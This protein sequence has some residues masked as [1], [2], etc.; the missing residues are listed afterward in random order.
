MEVIKKYKGQIY[1]H[2]MLNL[3]CAAFITF[4]SFSHYPL[5][6]FRAYLF[7]GAHFLAI[8]WS[9]FGF[10][11]F[12][13]ADKRF[14]TVFFPILFVLFSSI[15]F[16][17]YVQDI[18]IS[19]GI[20]Q[21][22]L[23]TKPDIVFGLI[24]WQF[25]LYF[26]LSVITSIILVWQRRKLLVNAWK[27]P[28]LI[29]ALIG[30][31][32]FF[33]TENYR[34]GSFSRR[35]P[36]NVFY[37]STEYFQQNDLVFRSVPASVKK[38]TDSLNVILVLGESV[39]AD[40]LQLN[41][42]IRQTTPLLSA[43]KN[44]IT[45]PDAFTPLTYTGASVPQIMTDATFSDSFDKPKYSLISVLKQAGIRTS[46]IG[47]QTPEK[48]FEMFP[49]QASFS[50]ILDPMHSE[51]SFR[52]DYDEKLLPVFDNVFSTKGNAFTAIHLMG[53][54]WWYETR[55]PSAFRIFQ[56]VINSKNVTSNSPEQLI[57]SYNNTILYM[58]YVVDKLIRK[59]EEKP[60]NTL[61]IY[62]SD[63]GEMLGEN[64]QWLHAQPG[65]GI[66]N[67]GLFFWYSDGF[68]KKYPQLI[69]RLESIRLKHTELE[70]FFPTVIDLFGI[71]GI[72]NKKSLLHLEKN[73]N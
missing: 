12:V 33:V 4:A 58:D 71:K 31:A 57:N 37:A 48:S 54:H 24:S 18:A 11:Y 34:T 46:W 21:V 41:G 69:K 27:S 63:H 60:S 35:L 3:A 28:L 5:H 8:Q 49:K 64:N 39:R 23:E 16:W 38:T 73:I 9:V 32:I 26:V 61:V 2:L 20:V 1:F 43:R 25:L 36:Y 70:F 66:S 44:I 7:Y 67:P 45:F 42:Y 22:S 15:A 53:S 65:K 59:I 40:H 10:L 13:S 52:K 56:P 30:I 19:Q 6:D 14:F 50:K 68:G 72:D 62:L 51:L 29:L 55:Y 17:V 47:N